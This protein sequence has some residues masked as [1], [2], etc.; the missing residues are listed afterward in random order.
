MK[1]K[2]KMPL[3]LGVITSAS[4]ISIACSNQATSQSDQSRNIALEKINDLLEINKSDPILSN[5]YAEGYKKFSEI[6]DKGDALE[7]NKFLEDLQNRKAIAVISSA[8][9]RPGD[10]ESK[11]DL[12]QVL[13]ILG[14]RSDGSDNGGELSGNLADRF[15]SLK[16]QIQ[17]ANS[18]NDSNL[19]IIENLNKQLAEIQR[20]VDKITANSIKR[21][22]SP[23]DAL[24]ITLSQFL[25]YLRDIN[26]TL[27]ATNPKH[28]Y[29]SS[30]RNTITNI[31][32][33]LQTA[34]ET[35]VTENTYK[36]LQAELELTLSQFGT[37][38]GYFSNEY[39]SPAQGSEQ[40]NHP[41]ILP[42]ATQPEKFMDVLFGYFI[43]RVDA[44]IEYLNKR[45]K[46]FTTNLTHESIPST[47]V[48]KQLEVLKENISKRSS[49]AKTF[50]D[51]VAV[52]YDF[53]PQFLD[54]MKNIPEPS[55]EP[56]IYL[57][58][59]RNNFTL[60]WVNSTAK[61]PLA[62]ASDP[63]KGRRFNGF[64][65]RNYSLESPQ[66]PLDN[67][68]I[69]ENTITLLKI[70]FQSLKEYWNDIQKKK[71]TEYADLFNSFYYKAFLDEFNKFVIP[72]DNG[73]KYL[74]Y[75]TKEEFYTFFED[76]KLLLE[77]LISTSL[78][79]KNSDLGRIKSYIES[80]Y[81]ENGDQKSGFIWT[82]Y[83][84]DVE[85]KIKKN[86][87]LQ[88]VKQYYDSKI[89][90]IKSMEE[91]TLSKAFDKMV[92][93]YSFWFELRAL[94]KGYNFF[95]DAGFD[96]I[97][98][99]QLQEILKYSQ[100]SL[101][102]DEKA[103]IQA[104]IDQAKKDL[105]EAQEKMDLWITHKAWEAI[106]VHKERTQI[107]DEGL[108][109]PTDNAEENKKLIKK[110]LDALKESL[111]YINKALEAGGVYGPEQAGS[112]DKTISGLKKYQATWDKYQETYNK[113]ESLT[114]EETKQF[115]NEYNE[116][117]KNAYDDLDMAYEYP[118][119][120]SIDDAQR[121][122]TKL[123]DTL[124][125]GA[126]LYVKAPGQE[127]YALLRQQLKESEDEINEKQVS[128]YYKTKDK[129]L[130]D[131]S[132]GIYNDLLKNKLFTSIAKIFPPSLK[133]DTD[134]ELQKEI[135]STYNEFTKLEEAYVLA[136]SKASTM[137]SEA[138][139]AAF[140]QAMKSY[141][142]FIRD[143]QNRRNLSELESSNQGEANPIFKLSIYKKAADDGEKG[144]QPFDLVD[145]YGKLS[146]VKGA[147]SRA[148]LIRKK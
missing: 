102:E 104:K 3:I 89:T 94:V 115:L 22:A 75:Q 77:N 12:E 32:N 15:E 105:K 30:V 31:T 40:L 28:V 84:Y 14:L 134:P 136:Q 60:I 101:P 10:S 107:G 65:E 61:S 127:I 35:E 73:L 58:S 57:S 146:A 118:E 42:F 81:Y 128:Q 53:L 83:K 91:D 85:D 4:I 133:Q 1:I 7:L 21:H 130:Y 116:L 5:W 82:T 69:D 34:N 121:R 90:K 148:E 19:K 66:N 142:D 37:Y 64:I 70:R 2:K 9:Y 93:L 62:E 54:E 52:Y 39:S 144:F 44:A 43:Q 49:E 56:K 80:L 79:T 33:K 71:D 92:A 67:A 27:S 48:A 63:S 72:T 109:V 87:N 111:P 41:A 119:Q 74:N 99:P 46:T 38:Y 108:V 125:E 47:L 138:N 6:K 106:A 97:E 124:K 143:D 120:D 36:N 147:L 126:A 50:V 98:D 17:K 26:T 117:W 11:K 139:K 110:Y 112:Y 8:V 23:K 18:D 95:I 100:D 132:Q 129:A 25:L 24:I 140:L 68:I 20:L 141:Y 135:V 59:I 122:I 13:G 88:D 51:Q 96:S 131:A 78:K 29:L 45:P 103:K 55:S 76:T 123:E 16:D 113:I 114:L 145:F 137:P 86:P